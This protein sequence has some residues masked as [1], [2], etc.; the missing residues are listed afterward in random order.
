MSDCY[1]AR[2]RSVAA[3]QLGDELIIM[4]ATDSTLF[5][6]NPVAAVIW[7]SADGKTPLA[8]IV[9]QQICP[10]FDVEFAEALRDAQEF[11]AALSTHGI[12]FVADSPILAPDAVAPASVPAPVVVTP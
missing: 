10:A 9:E 4:S 11:V 1:I 8:E 5:N 7:Q 3:R 12:L 2:S 6:L